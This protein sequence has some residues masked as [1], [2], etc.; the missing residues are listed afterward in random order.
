MKQ[1]GPAKPKSKY[2]QQ[3]QRR[4][5]WAEWFCR[6]WLRCKGYRI[7]AT[8]WRCPRGEIDII[9]RRHD[10]LIFVEVKARQNLADA[11]AAVTTRTQKRI[12]QTAMTFL[13]IHR[14]WQSLD[15]RFD[16]MMVT[17]GCFPQH[18][19]DAWRIHE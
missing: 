5:R 13:T 1:S 3:A 19:L 6:W 4:G 8:N 17:P 18:C 2:R 9:A 10:L 14:Q 11:G 16:V 15:T 12:T 7:I